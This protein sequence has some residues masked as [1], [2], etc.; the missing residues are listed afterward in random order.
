[1]LANKKKLS[2]KEVIKPAQKAKNPKSRLL[3]L[4]KDPTHH[5]KIKRSFSCPDYSELVTGSGLEPDMFTLTIYLYFPVSDTV[6]YM[7]CLPFFWFSMF[8]SWDFLKYSVSWDDVMSGGCCTVSAQFDFTQFHGQYT[9]RYGRK[10]PLYMF[11]VIN[12]SCRHARQFYEYFKYNNVLPF[13]D[14]NIVMTCN[15]SLASPFMHACDTLSFAV[16]S[17]FEF[18]H[19]CFASCRAC[20]GYTFLYFFLETN[21]SSPFLHTGSSSFPSFPV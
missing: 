9:R 2:A 19:C 21:P 13:N 14:E 1:M 11:F 7:Y 5:K 10:L 8:M 17:M 16:C 20:I 12:R 18:L 4:I 3:S 15:V 6:L